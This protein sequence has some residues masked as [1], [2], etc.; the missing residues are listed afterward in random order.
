[1]QSRLKSYDS[2]WRR[3]QERGESYWRRYAE[4]SDNPLV[5]TLR[6]AYGWQRNVNPRRNRRATKRYADGRQKRKAG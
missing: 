2:Q 4:T 6:Q 1:M 5:A 3:N